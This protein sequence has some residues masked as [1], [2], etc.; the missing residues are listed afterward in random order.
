VK[1]D[2]SAFAPGTVGRRLTEFFR[3]AGIGQDV[4]VTATNIR[5]MISDKA[6]EMSPTKKCLIHGHMKHQERTADQNYVIRLNADRA[7]KAHTLLQDIFQ[8]T[9]PMKLLRPPQ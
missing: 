6:F 3:Q 2:G 5:K 1:E 7:A 8:E 4:R 9:T